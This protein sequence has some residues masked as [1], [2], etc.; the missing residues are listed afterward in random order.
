MKKLL[1]VEDDTGFGYILKEYLEI[2][3]FAVTWATD[4]LQAIDLI[5][6]LA[7]DLCLL[8]IML[9]GADGFAVA[10]SIKKHESGLPF[11][12]LTAK[13]L[14]VDKLKG[15]RSGCDDYEVKPIDEELLVA[16]INAIIARSEKS[17]LQDKEHLFTIGEYLFDFNN[18]RLDHKG[19]SVILTQREAALLRL[20]CLHQNILVDRKTVLKEIWGISDLFTRKSMDVFISRLRKHLK[21]DSS[22]KIINIHNKGFVLKVG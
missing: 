11:I 20:L 12:F 2:K 16:K 3:G 13:G 22:V 4:G 8:D 15:F 9:P 17:I 21:D 10:D 18:L 14:K 5:Q 1:L 7:F 19:E 6:R